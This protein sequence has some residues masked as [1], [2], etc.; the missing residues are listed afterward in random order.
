MIAHIGTAGATGCAL[1]FAGS[2]TRALSVEGR[3]T[4][5]NMSI[6]AGA[7]CGL[8]A[9]DETTFAYLKGRPYAPKDAAFDQAVEAWSKLKTDDGAAFD[10]DVSL[11]AK[12]SRRS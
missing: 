9:P 6:E 11:D 8:V 1:E 12:T 5:C 10:Q 2:A 3:L 4:L 7:R